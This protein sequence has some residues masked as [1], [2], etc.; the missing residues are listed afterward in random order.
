MRTTCLPADF[1]LCI[2]NT[3]KSAQFSSFL[4]D[5]I[6]IHLLS[7][8]ILPGVLF[9][10]LLN[11]TY[12]TFHFEPLCYRKKIPSKSF[13]LYSLTLLSTPTL[14]S[15]PLSQ[16]KKQVHTFTFLTVFFIQRVKKSIFEFKLTCNWILFKLYGRLSSFLLHS[17]IAKEKTVL[18]FPTTISKHL[19][20]L[21]LFSSALAVAVRGK[22]CCV[23]HFSTFFLFLP[24]YPPLLFS[25]S[26]PLTL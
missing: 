2:E 12:A 22:L 17:T 26:F 9:F 1:Q 4:Q 14:S 8:I 19:S 13:V 16:N 11:L 15:S 3:K 10:L 21:P 23:F 6:A 25:V 5:A 20:Q 24:S 7:N 18:F